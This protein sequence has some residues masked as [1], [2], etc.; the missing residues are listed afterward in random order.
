MTKED[1]ILRSFMEH[2]LL[3]EKY[4]L[5]EEQLPNTVEEGMKS[6]IPI[7]LAITNIVKGVQRKPEVSDQDLQRQLFAILNSNAL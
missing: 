7:V 4:E 6:P 3:R 2:P 5:K 1:E